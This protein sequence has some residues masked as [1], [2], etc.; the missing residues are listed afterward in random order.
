MNTNSKT[1]SGKRI[2]VVDDDEIS[3]LVAMEI[4]EAL[5][6]EVLLANGPAEALRLIPTKSFDL[7]VLDLHMP[8]M[9]GSEL[10]AT[11]IRLDQSLK[12][13]IIFLTAQETGARTET[14]YATP[15]ITA[16]SKPLNPRQILEHFQKTD[17][18]LEQPAQTRPSLSIEGIDFSTGIKNFMGQEQAFLATLQMFPEYGRH[19]IEEYERNLLTENRKE[20]WRL[21]HSLKGSSAMIGAT[22]INALAK[23]LENLCGS[24]HDFD[25]IRSTFTKIRETIRAISKIIMEENPIKPTVE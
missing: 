12:N 11:L 6:A 14:G 2:L 10:A 1:L 22:G 21:A 3:R 4:L 20:C 23:D 9:H 13:R 7:I 18:L 16:L 25:M 24:S 19:F 15:N 8:E 5:G 17:P